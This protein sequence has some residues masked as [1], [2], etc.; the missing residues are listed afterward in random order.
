MQR[1]KSSGRRL[2]AH[3]NS[4]LGIVLALFVAVL[5]GCNLFDGVCLDDVSRFD[6]LETLDPDTAIK[7]GPGFR[8]V[9]LESPQ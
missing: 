3:A 7:A 9:F 5:A 6:I 1:F 2:G 4:S 8:D